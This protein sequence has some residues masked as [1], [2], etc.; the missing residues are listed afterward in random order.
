MGLRAQ[1]GCTAEQ[2]Q[3]SFGES[4]PELTYGWERAQAE[5]QEGRLLLLSPNESFL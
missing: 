4:Y 5:S 3:G 1:N 2:E